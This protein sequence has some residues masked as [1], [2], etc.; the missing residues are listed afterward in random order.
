MTSYF[1][2]G[3]KFFLK[4]CQLWCVIAPL[5]FVIISTL[6]SNFAFCDDVTR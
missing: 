2:N 6:F 5:D 1:H 3:A 4:F